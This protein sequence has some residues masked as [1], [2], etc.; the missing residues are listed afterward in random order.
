MMIRMTSRRKPGLRAGVRVL[1]EAEAK[2]GR[3]SASRADCANCLS[4]VP[5]AFTG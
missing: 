1:L 4:C 3:C 5:G 2:N